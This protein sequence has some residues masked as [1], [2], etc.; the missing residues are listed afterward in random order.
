[1][2]SIG[3]PGAA[4]LGRA[5]RPAVLVVDDEPGASSTERHVLADAGFDVVEASDSR[6][7]L[8]LL[9]QRR[10]AAV[11]LDIHVSGM[12]GVELIKAIRAESVSATV[13]VIVVT[14]DT[15]VADRIRG[16]TAGATDYVSKPFNSQELL[17]RVAAQ[18]RWHNSWMRLMEVQLRERSDLETALW[19]LNPEATPELTAELVCEQLRRVRGIN[20]AAILGFPDNGGAVPLAVHDLPLWDLQVG[21]QMPEE[22][23]TYLRQMADQGPWIERREHRAVRAASTEA[24]DAPGMVACAPLLR[25]RFVL[26]LLILTTDVPGGEAKAGGRFRAMS[27]AIDFADIAS[28][29]LGPGLDERTRQLTQR[30]VIEQVLRTQA[31]HPIFEPIVRLRDGS[32]TGYE[33]LTRFE[34]GAGP[35][36]R[37]SMAASVNRRGDLER[38]TLEAAVRAAGGL[39]PDCFVSLNVSPELLLEGRSLRDILWNLDRPVVLELT[40]HDPI[41]DYAALRRA[42]ADL[43]RSVQL[44]VDDAGSGFASLQHI[45]ALEPAFVKLDKSWI[46]GINGDPTRQA[47]IAGLSHFANQTGC[48]LI[49][50]GI[51]TLVDLDALRDLDVELG[52]GYLFG[53]PVGGAPP[54]HLDTASSST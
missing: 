53:H 38:A 39:P 17:A 34:D 1:M 31:F 25:D 8:E 26:G 30:S 7:A 24:A 10:F 33:A 2:T 48:H 13:P 44:S 41:T 19:R 37:F 22:L 11:V 32:V 21:R 47:L 42:L 52:Q 9:S 23:A 29:L 51:E 4:V 46:I 20:A 16:L 3:L 54:A 14:N 50:E 15:T 40:E 28:G 36:G 35:E 12:A 45:L 49:A 6:Y 5:S 27:A 43:G 18:V